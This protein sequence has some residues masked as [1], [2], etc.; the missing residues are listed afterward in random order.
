[1]PGAEEAELTTRGVRT[2]TLTISRSP[3]ARTTPAEARA[4]FSS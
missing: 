3:T 4:S 2:M 1:M